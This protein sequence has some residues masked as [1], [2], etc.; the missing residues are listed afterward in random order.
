MFFFP[1]GQ[2]LLVYPILVPR[3]PPPKPDPGEPL[4]MRYQ[5]PEAAVNIFP[6][7]NCLL[8]YNT[9][10]GKLEREIELKKD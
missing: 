8:V 9:L 5:T 2:H 3:S 4:P 7:R 1:G 6:K 10:D